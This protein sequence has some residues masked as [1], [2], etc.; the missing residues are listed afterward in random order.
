MLAWEMTTKAAN[1]KRATPPGLW[2]TLTNAAGRELDRRHAKDEA[3]AVRV[4]ILML[5][6]RNEFNDGDVLTAN[7]DTAK[8]TSLR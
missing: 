6:G 2:L 1:R 4:A 7:K 5:A 8:V 3:A